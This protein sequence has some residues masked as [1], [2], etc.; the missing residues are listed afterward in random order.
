[1]FEE[2]REAV[3]TLD[4]AARELDPGRL[5]GHDAAE[6]LDDFARGERLCAA[7]KALLA[8]RVD[9]ANV[10]RE[11]GH[12]SAAHWVAEVT[13]E[14]VAAAT[15]SLE[16]ARRLEQLPGTEAAFRAGALSDVQA[17]EITATAVAE[18]PA[19]SASCSRRRGRRA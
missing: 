18:T 10:W 3:A 12:R 5:D 8:R 1:V 4:A 15:R 9:D 6:L 11:S 19:P 7:A 13:G 14:T 17:A 2:V 16:T